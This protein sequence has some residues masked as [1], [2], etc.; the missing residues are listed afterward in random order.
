MNKNQSLSHLIFFLSPNCNLDCIFCPHSKGEIR[1][2]SEENLFKIIDRLKGV[3][4]NYIVLTGGEPS[5]VRNLPE[6]IGYIRKKLKVRYI[7]LNSNGVNLSLKVLSAL[8]KNQP[9]LLKFSIHSSNPLLHNRITGVNGSFE[10]LSK[11]IKNF[12]QLRKNDRSLRLESNTVVFDWNYKKIGQLID[13]GC[14]QE[15]DSMQFSL[16]SKKKYLK[17]KNQ[18]S[19]LGVNQ[20]KELYFE[21]YPSLL[22]KAVKARIRVEFR[23]IFLKLVGLSQGDLLSRLNFSKDFSNEITNYSKGFYGKEFYRKYQC[24]VSQNGL[25]IDFNGRVYFCCQDHSMV[26]GN[27]LTDDLEDVFYRKKEARSNKCLKCR[28]FFAT[29]KQ[30]KEFLG[31]V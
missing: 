7:I 6:L 30:Y 3:S 9:A 10:G 8:A 18:F 2:V 31:E 26:L 13:W 1:P 29:N 11:T 4:A 25:T 12:N 23:P 24:Y 15:I 28:S 21:I 5:L 16:V 14:Q 20:L 22:K 27:I 19:L 17:K